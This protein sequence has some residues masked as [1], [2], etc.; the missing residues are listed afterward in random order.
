VTEISSTRRRSWPAVASAFAIILLFITLVGVKALSYA[1]QIGTEIQRIQQE[2]E[3]SDQILDELRADTYAAAVELGDYLMASPAESAGARQRFF[4]IEERMNR[5]ATRLG[6]ALGPQVSRPVQHLRQDLTHYS[7]SVA[8]IFKWTPSERQAKGAAF[9]RDNLVPERAAVLNATGEIESLRTIDLGRERA[10]LTRAREQFRKFG[11]IAM[12][13]LI[14]FVLTVGFVTSLRLRF[15]EMRAQSL[16]LQTEEDREK[17]RNLSLQMSKALEDERRSISRELH[18]QIGQLLTAIQMK[19]NKIE[20]STDPSERSRS[21][22][23]GKEL[24]YRTVTAARDLAMGLRPSVLDDLGLVA[25]LEWQVREFK[26]RSGI[27]VNL[28]LEGNLSEIPDGHRTC[29]YRIVQEALT[30]CGRHSE[31]KHVELTVHGGKDQISLTVW[32]DGKGFDATPSTRR[33]L[34]LVGIEERARELGGSAEIHSEPGKGTL[35]E[36]QIPSGS[37]VHA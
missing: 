9:L 15:L 28:N 13:A 31:A 21:V 29:L 11:L 3:Q 35:L 6:A 24:V 32:D 10:E 26:R 7:L 25:A 30:N 16:Q 8:P 34:G 17:L 23:A 1:N 27:L 22:Q 5:G 20:A 18:D 33:G 36:V 2:Q 19:F 14:L 37:E 12:L 4:Q